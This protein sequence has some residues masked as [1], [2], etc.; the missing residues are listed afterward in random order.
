MGVSTMG[1]AETSRPLWIVSKCPG[2]WDVVTVGSEER[3]ATLFCAAYPTAERD[4][5]LEFGSDRVDG[6]FPLWWTRGRRRDKC[7]E[8][9]V[10]D[11]ETIDAMKSLLCL[12]SNPVYFSSA[13]IR[14]L[15]GTRSGRGSACE[16]V[17][18]RGLH[19]GPGRC[20]VTVASSAFDDLLRDPTLREELKERVLEGLQEVANL[21]ATGCLLFTSVDLSE[22]LE[23]SG[24]A[25]QSE[26]KHLLAAALVW[27]GKVRPETAAQ[28]AGVT[29]SE[30]P[31][32]LHRY[33]VET[34]D[35]ILGGGP[36]E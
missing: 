24:G 7:G 13:L 27:Q 9:P 14:G 22:A 35:D 30:L 4:V 23:L 33:G 19:A 5:V 31:E 28:V 17:A 10:F 16:A 21:L 8:L 18:A 1:E 12:A 34:P 6:W 3:V 32:L 2:V 29:Q 11:A 15:K 26:L 25:M 20:V 36:S